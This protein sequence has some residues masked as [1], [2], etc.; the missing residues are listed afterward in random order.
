MKQ[1]IKPNQG[2]GSNPKP[3]MTIEELIA[4]LSKFPKDMPVVHSAEGMI[5]AITEETLDLVKLEDYNKK[6]FYEDILMIGNDY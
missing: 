4:A 6:S 5:G 2:H 3:T 1:F